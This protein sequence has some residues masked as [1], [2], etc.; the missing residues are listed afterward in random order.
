MQEFD[1]ETVRQLDINDRDI[2]AS[3]EKGREPRLAVG[4]CNDFNV[5]RRKQRL[6]PA[7]R[8]EWSS[9]I[10]TRTDEILIRRPPCWTALAS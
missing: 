5:L 9:T 8:I 3:F 2:W 10:R 1:P 4:R 6:A 7:T